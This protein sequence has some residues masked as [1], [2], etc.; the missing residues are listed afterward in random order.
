MLYKRNVCV[1]YNHLKFKDFKSNLNKKLK[2]R[3]TMVC[4]SPIVR[5][6]AARYA[7]IAFLKKVKKSEKV[8]DKGKKKY[9]MPRCSV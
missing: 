4:E 5:D 8:I 7:T 3:L 6:I 2:K 1:N 9:I